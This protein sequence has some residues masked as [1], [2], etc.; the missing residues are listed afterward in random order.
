MRLLTVCVDLLMVASAW[1]LAFFF[2]FYSVLPI[3]K[4]IPF[5]ALYLKL[6]PFIIVIWF[7]TFTLSGFYKRTGKHSSPL[8]EGVDALQ[9]CLLATLLFIAVTYFYD[10]YR[11]SRLTLLIF[12]GLHP[13]FLIA[14]R[15]LVR[16]GLR[17]YKRRSLARKVLIIASDKTLDDACSLEKESLYEKFSWIG[18][19][20]VDDGSADKS[21]RQKYLDKNIPLLAVPKDWVAFFTEYT[22]ESVII[23][24]PHHLY[25]FFDQHLETIVEQ[26]TTVKMLPDVKRFTKFATGVS[27][28]NQ[29]P[30]ISIHESPLQGVGILYKRSLDI[31]GALAALVIF[32]P[33]MLLIAALTRLSS[34]GPIFYRQERM[35]LDGKVFTIL[36]FRSMPLDS[37]QQT[38]A[39]WASSSDKRATPLGSLLRK[40]SLDELPQLWNVLRGDMSLVGPRPERP[41]FVNKFRQNI[42]GYMLR[43][44]VKA[45]MTGWAQVNGW[46]GNTSIDKRIECDLYYIQNWSLWLDIKILILTVVRGF[47]HPHAY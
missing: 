40:A 42:P 43:H 6:L 25:T 19:V 14:G 7:F 15:S 17:L 11:Y 1:V 20:L 23:A 2:R 32:S 38:G 16:K 39:V 3:L 33:L 18:V 28:V 30:V 45:G 29:M 27:L 10:E 37:E 8:L 4:G 31:I 9:S 5:W 13:L 36:K 34:A 26:V 46:R 47:I 12:A 22:C 24:L 44:K 21:L 41:V 35:G